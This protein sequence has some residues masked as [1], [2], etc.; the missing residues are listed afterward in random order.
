M[1]KIIKIRFII[2]FI[3]R[4]TPKALTRW[5]SLLLSKDSE[6][7]DFNNDV[8]VWKSANV[9]LYPLSEEHWREEIINAA[10]R[11]AREGQPVEAPISSY[12]LETAA[13]K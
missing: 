12:L 3:S 4:L 5:E 10:A 7:K 8:Y 2:F 9:G 11:C 6:A 1:N 13:G